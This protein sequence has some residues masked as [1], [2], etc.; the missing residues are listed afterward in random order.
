MGAAARVV[1]A[2]AAGT[3]AVCT[4]AVGIGVACVGIGGAVAGLVGS[5]IWVRAGDICGCTGACAGVALRTNSFGAEIGAAGSLGAL[6]NSSETDPATDVLVVRGVAAEDARCAGVAERPSPGVCNSGGVV[7]SSGAVSGFVIATA[8]VAI[9]P[10]LL[11]ETPVAAGA[12][13]VIILVSVAEDFASKGFA[14]ALGGWKLAANRAVDGAV[15]LCE[16]GN[17]ELSTTG[18]CVFSANIDSVWFCSAGSVD[19]GASR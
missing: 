1:V 5:A 13:P 3:G 19:C 15:I 12:G 6:L 17:V 16:I 14:G 2:D 9:G 7:L 8:G 10:V 18:R 11:V 4:G